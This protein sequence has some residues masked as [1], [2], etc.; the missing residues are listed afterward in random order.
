MLRLAVV[1]FLALL[2]MFGLITSS[3]VA[4]EDKV[5]IPALRPKTQLFSRGSPKC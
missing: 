4:Y 3:V 5:T 2:G 1:T